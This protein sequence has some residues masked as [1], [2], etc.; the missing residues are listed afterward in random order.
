LIKKLVFS[1]QHTGKTD[2]IQNKNKRSSSTEVL[3]EN[4][5]KSKKKLPLGLLHKKL[6][7]G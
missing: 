2:R 3:N 6:G 7:K 5:S 1:E 4:A